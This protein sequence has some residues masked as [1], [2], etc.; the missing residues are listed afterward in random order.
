MLGFGAMDARSLLM[1]VAAVGCSKTPPP[2]KNADR[3]AASGL[4]LPGAAPS[5]PPIVHARPP[6]KRACTLT[7]TGHQ[8]VAWSTFWTP[9]KRGEPHPTHARSSYWANEAERELTKNR[10]VD[11]PLELTCAGLPDSGLGGAVS[12][13]ARTSSSKEVPL[14]SKSYDIAPATQNPPGAG[15]FEVG[16]LL[17]GESLYRSLGGTLNVQRFD[18]R[19]VA[20]DFAL[21]AT[22]VDGK[23]ERIHLKGSF[24]IPC[25]DVAQSL[26]Q[27]G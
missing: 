18:A 6:G 4:P 22:L 20:G 12:L 13:V 2:Q 15:A 8:H 16:V 11:F 25:G 27:S 17:V 7:V 23:G 26:C 21:D 24:D 3:P 19:G 10:H 9:P 14:A 1:L 5:E